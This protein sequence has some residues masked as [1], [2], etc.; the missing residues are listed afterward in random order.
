MSECFSRHPAIASRAIVSDSRVHVRVPV[1]HPGRRIN[2][3]GLGGEIDPRERRRAPQELRAIA[4]DF[5]G[6][7]R[8]FV[9]LLPSEVSD[10]AR[11]W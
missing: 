6:Q 9:D 10:P 7:V 4:L 11:F 8:A 3:P 5:E 1:V 2:R